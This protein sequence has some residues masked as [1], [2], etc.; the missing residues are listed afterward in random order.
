MKRNRR[1][2]N[3]TTSGNFSNFSDEFNKEITQVD[4]QGDTGTYYYQDLDVEFFFK[5]ILALYIGAF[6]EKYFKPL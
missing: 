4:C 2:Y 6:I 3:R 5:Q 1:I